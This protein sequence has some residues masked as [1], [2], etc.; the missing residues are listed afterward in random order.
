MLT[1]KKE[2]LKFLLYGV[3]VF[4]EWHKTS[5]GNKTSILAIKGKLRDLNLFKGI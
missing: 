2:R 1:L 3:N 5:Y 4:I